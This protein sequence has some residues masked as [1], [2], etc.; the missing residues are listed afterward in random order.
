MFLLFLL[1][2]PATA[3]AWTLTDRCE[4]TRDTPK[5]AV[6]VAPTPSGILL[7]LPEGLVANDTSIRVSIGNTSWQMP[8]VGGAVELEGAVKPLLE[9]N[10]ATVHADGDH[11]LGFNLSGF[12]ETWEKLQDCASSVDRGGWVSLS[13]EITAATDDQIIAAIRRRRPAGLLL[14]SPGG[15]AQEAQRIGDA[16]REAKMA[17]KVRANGQCLS[18]CVFVFAAGTPRAI[19]AG[20]RVGIPASLITKGLGVF[21]GD[22]ESVADSAAYFNAMGV[23][24]GRMAVLATA[25]QSDDIRVFTPQELQL[26]GLV[27]TSEP[28]EL[29]ATIAQRFSETEG[30]DW[31]LLGGLLGFGALVWGLV[32]FFRKA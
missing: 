26:L 25:A 13:G 11:V 27:D 6:V 32:T 2:L 22:Q 17:T 19:E 14:D 15:L 30:G 29:A 4:L 28:K 9:K 8:L 18:E 16:V 1:M 10:W 21:L 24:G 5:G 7:Y 12:S 20:G 23:K 31:W 3:W